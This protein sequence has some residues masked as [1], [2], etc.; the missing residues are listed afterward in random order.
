MQL[1][2]SSEFAGHEHVGFIRDRASDLHAIIA[3]HNTCRGPA[4]GGCRAWAYV[5]EAQALQDALRLSRGMTY[6][7]AVADIPFGGGKAVVMLGRSRPKTPAMMRALGNAIERLGGSYV[8]GEDVGTTA[9][10]ME[11][12]RK[13]TDR[14]MGAPLEAGGSGDPSPSTARG[15]FVG[16]QAS[17]RHALRLNDLHGVSV[18]VQ[19]LGN[20][21]FNLC[22]MLVAAG[23]TLIVS[24]LDAERVQRCVR[25]F[26]ARAVALDEIYDAD[27][28]VFAPC[29]LGSILN[30]ANIARLRTPV[31]AGAANNQLET[32]DCAD[33]LRK[34]GILYAPDYVIN[35]GGMIQLAS[36]RLPPGALDVRARIEAIHDTLL[37]LYRIAHLEGVSTHLAAERLA[38]QRFMPRVR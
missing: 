9:Q 21:G 2:D 20:V 25:E 34:R 22:R 29:A 10:D 19:G 3:I 30:P 6:K 8:T 38:E 5:D 31:V 35:A 11:E 28:D 15:C 32:A 33:L 18:A 13:V 16:I 26:D 12:I 17:V 1:S 24:D 36:E 37:E 23:A 4:L 27:A 14:V 7:A